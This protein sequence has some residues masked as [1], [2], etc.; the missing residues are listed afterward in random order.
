[1]EYLTYKRTFK[2]VVLLNISSIIAKLLGLFV[3]II[4]ARK[5]GELYFGQ[6]MFVF[7]FT[8][9]FLI[10]N[11]FGL[12]S[13][14]ARDITRDRELSA[15]YLTEISYLKI[16]MAFILFLIF[17][18]LIIILPY[19]IELKYALIIGFFYVCIKSFGNFFNSFFA[20]FERL[21]INAVLDFSFTFLL[22]IFIFF[23]SSLNILTLK[24][25][26]IVHLLSVFLW[27]VAGY[28]ILKV[29]F[30]PLIN[31]SGFN[32]KFNFLKESSI[33]LL[34]TISGN[35]ILQT[36]VV[37]L[38]FLK[39]DIPTG[40]YG[41]T[42]S[43]FSGLLFLTAN[44]SNAVFPAFTRLFKESKENLKRYFITTIEIF[45][46]LTFP[47]SIGGSILSEKIVGLVYGWRY[48]PA[49][50]S[51][52]IIMW[53]IFF[54]GIGTFF[55]TFLRATNRQSIL[56]KINIYGIIFNVL[57]SIIF[58]YYLSHIGAAI[59]RTLT[60]LFLCIF[61]YLVILKDD[62]YTQLFKYFAKPVISGLLMGLLV[63]LLRD[64]FNI[65]L[66]I[67]LGALSYFIF[68]TSIRGFTKEEF[69]II[70][71]FFNK[72]YTFS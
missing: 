35:L 40:Y 59:S 6:L 16:F 17:V 50:E 43:F 51:F 25:S 12:N 29:K 21:D 71:S 69:N 56:F 31:N 65:F 24:I 37:I 60:L 72:D 55:G 39:G 9:V 44:F 26:L 47:I 48:L 34:G 32:I 28:I 67:F 22:F 53:A 45:F 70:K 58:I 63:Y 52:S 14:V 41:T 19:S 38:K 2:N 20:G 7:S 5:L 66:L 42:L 4:L 46:I 15:K 57:S 64:T 13:L 62:K 27:A 23:L 33:F 36:D 10:L 54:V 61:Y 8:S 49:V 68:L 3:S 30:V 18:G 1:M 11:D